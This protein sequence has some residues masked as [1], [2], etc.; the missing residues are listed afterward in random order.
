MFGKRRAAY[1]EQPSPRPWVQRAGL[2]EPLAQQP[3]K[4]AR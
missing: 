3:D 4:S 2:K 1:G